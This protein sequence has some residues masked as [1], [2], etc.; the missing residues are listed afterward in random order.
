[1]KI[2]KNN[3]K[4]LLITLYI[5]SVLLPS[6]KIKDNKTLFEKLNELDGFTITKISSL[7]GFSECFQIDISQPIDHNNPNGETF[8]QRFYLSHREESLPMVFYTT[9]YGVNRNSEK[10]ITSLIQ[11]NQILLVHRY[12]PNAIPQAGW[13][14]LTIWQ[15]ASDQHRIKELLKKIYIGNWV[16]SGGSKGGMTSLFYRYYFPDDITAT[17]AYVAPIMT[18]ENDIRFIHFLNSVGT[19]KCRE[20]IKT[21]QRMMLQKKR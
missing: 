20:K 5:I 16:S 19:E 17:V 10:G 12:F 3:L 6:C 7:V 21:F 11:G 1:M 15:A 4:Y 2:I 14:Y 13:E 8:K 18:S 9:G